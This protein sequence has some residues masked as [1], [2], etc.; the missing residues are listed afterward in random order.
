M[1]LCFL[2]VS[3]GSNKIFAANAGAF[4]DNGVGARPMALGQAYVSIA[5]DSTAGYWNP[6]GLGFLKK[7]DIQTMFVSNVFDYNYIFFGYA[8][9]T[10]IGSFG[11]SLITAGTT[12]IPLVASPN[13]GSRPSSGGTFSDRSNA[14][15]ISYAYDFS[16]KISIG[17]NLKHVWQKLHTASAGGTG[18]DFGVLGKPVKGLSIGANF[19]NMIAPNMGW[20]NTAT[21]PSEKL[22]RKVK[23]G[24]NYIHKGLLI[25]IDADILS[26][27][28][29]SIHFGLEYKL[30]KYLALRGGYNYINSRSTGDPSFGIGLNFENFNFDYAFTSVTG[31]AFD[32]MIHR[33]SFGY[34]FGEPIGKRITTRKDFKD[35]LK[36]SREKNHEDII[37]E[38]EENF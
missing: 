3:F 8:M 25:A 1:L 4:L 15:F 27:A 5:D 34:K 16:P 21:N 31:S 30:G 37:K 24:M 12:G 17:F 38:Y 19:V 29:D 6:A 22:K 7:H 26:G 33:L 11:F 20:S 10:R 9:P 23:L 36:E 35:R 32:E 2:F 14:F 28:K 18:I 13:A